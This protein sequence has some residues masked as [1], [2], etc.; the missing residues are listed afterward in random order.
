MTYRLTAV[1]LIAATLILSGCESSEER[2]DEHFQTALEFL[3]QGDRKRAILEMRNALQLVPTHEE[4]RQTLAET[5]MAEGAL[6]PA[7]NNYR[8]LVDDHPDNGEGHLVLA[9]IGLDLRDWEAVERHGTKAEEL[10]G[11]TP[12]VRAVLVNLAYRNALEAEDNEA[13]DAAVEEAAMLVEADPALIFGRMVVL[14]RALRGE[15]WLVALELIDGGLENDPDRYGLYQARLPVLQQ[16]GRTD[17]VTA[18][19]EDMVER[20]PEQ[21]DLPLTL[22]RWYLSQEQTGDAEAYLRRR[23]EAEPDDLE[24][25]TQLVQFLNDTKGAEAASEELRRLAAAGGENVITFRAMDANLAFQSGRAEEAIAELESIISGLSEEEA[26]S[27]ISN[28]VRVDLARMKAATGD[29]DAARALVDEILT[30]DPG[31]VSALKMRA[32]W[33]IED[34]EVSEAIANLRLALRDSPRDVQ[35]MTLMAAAHERL[36]EAGLQREMLA[37]AVETSNSGPQESLRYAQML[38]SEGRDRTAE[39]VLVDSLRQNPDNVALLSALGNVYIQLEDWARAE[40]VK[41][42]LSRIV[43]AGADQTAVATLNTL[44][45]R[46]L[47]NQERDTELFEF[48]DELAGSEQGGTAADIAI[49]RAH[50]ARGDVAEARKRLEKLIEES[51][52]QPMLTFISAALSAADGDLAKAEQEMEALLDVYPRSEP[53]WTAL[54]RMKLVQGDREGASEVLDRALIELPD[55]ANLLF[56]RAGELEVAGDIDGAIDIYEAL[57]ERNSSSELVANNLASLLSMHRADEETLERAFT[58]G[59]RLQDSQNPAM[60]DTYGWIAARMGRHDEAES[61]LEFAAKGFPQHP[62]VLYHYAVNLAALGRTEEALRYF[63][64]AEAKAGQILPVS[65]L[66]VVKSEIARLE[67]EL[68]GEAEPAENQ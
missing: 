65:D 6:R 27:S 23:A 33:Q 67:A 5:Q 47:A 48:L 52:E 55:A 21:A 20:F 9:E 36:G 25:Q 37:L 35:I 42:T 63:R 29:A 12:E 62:V 66:E 44:Q 14:D 18:Q 41:A 53:V 4:A 11:E 46:L 3:E 57:Y 60:R 31:K 64:D 1:A 24:R 39:D 8:K 15:D 50:A 22:V 38:L 51:G 26:T 2:A 58:I 19:L 17:A 49:I 28:D 61:H 10:L 43:E 16:L 54:F 7:V 13:R 56:S 30:N 34:D 68:A 59:R 45:A 32:A 40:Q